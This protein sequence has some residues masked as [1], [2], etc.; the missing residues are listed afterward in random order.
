MSSLEEIGIVWINIIYD[1]LTNNRR[2]LNTHMQAVS[3]RLVITHTALVFRDKTVIMQKYERILCSAHCK[4]VAKFIRL[5]QNS[6]KR[7]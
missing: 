7:Q 2:R 1:I 3:P 4:N 5:V 6:R